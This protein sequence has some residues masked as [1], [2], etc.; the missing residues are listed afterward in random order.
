M[1]FSFSL[2]KNQLKGKVNKE[3]IKELS[4]LFHAE[5]ELISGATSKQKQLLVKGVEKGELERLIH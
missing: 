4:R 2:P 1:R 3:I 5:V